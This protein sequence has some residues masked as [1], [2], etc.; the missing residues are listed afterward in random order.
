MTVLGTNA[1]KA[2]IMY[3]TVRL[4]GGFAWRANARKSAETPGWKIEDPVDLGLPAGDAAVRVLWANRGDAPSV[5]RVAAEVT[6]P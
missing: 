4:F 6:S 1:V 2:R 3:W 5:R